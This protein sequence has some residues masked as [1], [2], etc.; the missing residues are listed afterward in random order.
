MV[1]RPAVNSAPG[2]GWRG[3]TF[4]P[5]SRG[6]R[7]LRGLNGI[8]Y[9]APVAR[10]SWLRGAGA[11]RVGWRWGS[12]PDPFGTAPLAGAAAPRGE[13][14]LRVVGGPQRPGVP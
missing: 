6:G 5:P 13:G 3:T 12:A 7:L 11:G 10:D 8:P 1:R 2:V 9:K 4:L 14:V